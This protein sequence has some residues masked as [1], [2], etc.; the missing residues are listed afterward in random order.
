MI[1]LPDINGMSVPRAALAYVEAGIPLAP[2]DATKGNGKQCGNL[3]GN[4]NDSTD[5]WYH[6]VTTDKEQIKAWRK[7]FGRF[8]ALATSPGEF[9]CVVIDLDYPDLWPV[10]W[11]KYLKDQSVPYVNTRPSVHKRKGHYWFTLPT[12][13]PALTNSGIFNDSGQRCGE[14]RCVKGGLILPPYTN[15]D[16]GDMRTVVRSGTPPVLPDELAQYFKAG[17]GVRGVDISLEEFCAKYVAAD[18]KRKDKLRGLRSYH[19]RSTK[20]P[21]DAMRDVLVMGLGE[22]RLGYVTARQVIATC[23]ELWPS[24]RPASEFSRL[25][26]SA[27]RF[28]EAQDIDEIKCRSDRFKGSDSRRCSHVLSR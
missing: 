4:P 7:R 14:L 20:V 25:C 15:P 5:N 10:R 2:F 8:Q 12:T 1:E 13:A 24:N 9:G 22:A 23:R 16:T 6:H 27:A 19:T 18:P 26:A 21:H 3:V 28:V 17:A 11:R